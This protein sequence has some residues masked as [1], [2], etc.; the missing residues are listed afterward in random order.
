MLKNFLKGLTV[1]FLLTS[2]YG[3]TSAKKIHVASYIQERERVD[4]DL[5]GNAGFLMGN[6]SSLNEGQKQKTRQVFV[7]EVSKESDE[8]QAKEK[9]KPAAMNQPSESTSSPL[10]DVQTDQPPSP[11]TMAEIKQAGVIEYT[12]EK[13]DTLQKV[14]KKYYNSYGK[15]IKIY[16][17][18]KAVIKDP[19]HI[20]PGITLKIPME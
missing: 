1:I 8:D 11:S 2:I 5:S 12:V 10:S 6:T 18:N 15:W 17:A 9:T 19:N 16:E 14:A 13:D 20:K 7:V 3:C 4:Q